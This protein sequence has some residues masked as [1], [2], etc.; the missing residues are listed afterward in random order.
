MTLRITYC[1][2]DIIKETRSVGDLGD[3]KEYRFVSQIDSA[4][5]IEVD[6]GLP[7]YGADDLSAWLH[8]AKHLGVDEFIERYGKYTHE[9]SNKSHW[10]WISYLKVNVL[11]VQEA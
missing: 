2:V 1:P 7:K 3:I 5:T 11:E 6:D 9:E 8:V 4:K 10:R